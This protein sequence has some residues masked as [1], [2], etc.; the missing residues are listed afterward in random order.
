MRKFGIALGI[1]TLVIILAVAIFALT[2][3]INRYHGVIQAEL[4]KQLGRNVTFGEM[5]LKVIPLRFVANDVT[6]ADD[7]KLNTQTPFVKAHELDV[8]PKLL[9]L[10]HKS[11]EID[12][13]YLQR[14]DV[15]L[16][17]EQNGQWN[18]S[19][20]GGEKAPA[21]KKASEEKFSLGKLTIQDGQVAMT[22]R[23]AGKARSV[24]DHIGV[25]LTDFAPDQEFSF[26][27]VVRLPGPGDQQIQLQGRGGPIRQDQPADTPFHGTLN[28]QRVAISGA[29]QF[30]SSPA[31]ANMDGS[32]SGQAKVASESGKLSVSGA[33]TLQNARMNGQDLG[34]PIAAQYSVHHDVQAD[35]LSIDSATIKLGSTPLEISGTVNSKP[36]P[37][38]I[39]L[40]LKANGIS[41]AETAR[42]AALSGAALKPGA[43]VGGTL[44]ANIEARGAA[45]TPALNGTINVRG[46]QVSG[47]DFPQ[48]VQ[49][50]ALALNLTPAEIRSN[51]FAVKSGATSM[52]V[53]FALQQYLSRNPMVNAT[54]QAP[55]AELPAVLSI[56]KAY[57]ITSLDK[58]G[59][60]GTLNLDLHAA[61]PVQ[62]VK[63]SE[64]ARAL[65][66]TLVLNFHDVHYSGADMSH[67][68]SAIAGV[69]GLHQA[70]Q[71]TTNINK[72]T[73]KTDIK[74]G[75]AQTNNL[76]ALLDIGNVGITGTA[77]L[78]NDQLN[79]RVSVVISK[80][81][82]QKAG[83]TSITG[84]AKTALANSDGELVIPAIITGTFEHPRF[85]PDLQQMAQMKMKGL[86]PNFNNPS[87]AI[88]GALGNLLNQK[89][90]GNG[91]QSQQPSETQNPVQQLQGLFGKKKQQQ[92][93]LP[94]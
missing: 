90:G 17:K 49:V 33:M 92:Q 58:V 38:Q 34:Y 56:A 54:V 24:Y 46:L 1:I 45:D 10:L 73:G 13:L 12:S 47:K 55:N 23:E 32:F 4:T 71:G 86:V 31:L 65:N 8:S 82:S 89:Q 16:I 83:G 85:A 75:I 11:V 19:S 72:L 44:D 77:N 21:P 64:L 79:L 14:P 88:S 84:Y 15:E 78:V 80:E 70:N 53:Q 7:P 94:K 51:Q 63:S 62:S 9:P 42:L 93:Q 5:S 87:A 61:G 59:G 29:R 76:E 27:A 52:N 57:G 39:E 20:L 40:R 30:V 74:N 2:F 68:L 18:F 28:L 22:D 26:D 37:A 43:T 91:T 69:I 36:T 25:T 81:L 41:I 66:G 35:L 60:Q 48:P 3:D 50:E 67:E 6:I